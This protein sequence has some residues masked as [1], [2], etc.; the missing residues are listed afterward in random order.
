ME[1]VRA[2][3]LGIVAACA[4]LGAAVFATAAMDAGAASRPGEPARVSARLPYQ[5]VMP[6]LL[7]N[8]K[9]N[10]SAIAQN[11]GTAP[12]TIAMDFYTPAGVLISGASIVVP[13]VP[14][15]GTHTFAQAINNGLVP[16][17][18][19]VGVLSS[20]QPINA[21]LVRD[22]EQNGTGRKSYSIH[23]AFSTGGNT[24]TL[25]YV[26]N[27][28]DNT[29]NTRFA[30]ANTGNATACVTITYS[31]VGGGRA[32]V[33]DSGSGGSGCASGYP[34]PVSGQVAFGP[35][36]VPA[37]ATL[38]MPGGTNNG[39][40]AATVTSTGAPVTVAVDAYLTSGPRKLA[41]YDGFIVG[42][43]AS[44]LGQ[45][46]A[47]PLS[48]KTADGFYSQILMSN[49]NGSDA[50]VT[51]TYKSSSGST[52][53]VSK[54]VPA[55]GTA[56]HSVYED[57]TVPV[58][59]VG[60][61]TIASDQPI[62]AVLFRA[63]M[64]TA[65]SYVDEDLYTAVNGV[66]VERATTTAKLPLIFRR[67]YGNNASCGEGGGSSCGYNSWVSVTVASGSTANLTLTTINDTASGTPGCGAA[68]T[69]TTTFQ[70]TAG[71]KVFYQNLNPGGGDSN[72]LGQ[73]PG[74][75]WGGMVITSDV[76]IIA[77]ANVT[78]DLNPGDNDGAYNAFT[79]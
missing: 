19:G 17:F 3:T 74:C 56:N 66:P 41:A 52:S 8:S 5:Q 69:Y 65:G 27:N 37:E 44:D 22:I 35:V 47:I 33:T 1:R 62:A 30:I 18:R 25:P 45:N 6:A 32:P 68:A 21:L 26:A 15:G 60:A 59:F 53:T 49:P 67:A 78:N 7:P 23:N 38:A 43:S 39:L 76:P 28:L 13:N 70:I 12:A 51:I 36:A 72:G 46:I 48:L 34:V 24:V 20:D 63:K 54:T 4:A 57:S 58:G 29:Y 55:N 64:T 42:G 61:A 50:H 77:I 2:R 31:F 79:N 10:T 73:N 14:V 71:T 16:G 40:M 9:E 75:L 11:N